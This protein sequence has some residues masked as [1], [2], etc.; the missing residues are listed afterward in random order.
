MDTSTQTERK[1][2]NP[3]PLGVWNVAGI[4]STAQSVL[5][6]LGVHSNY[7][8]DTIIGVERLVAKTKLSKRAVYKGLQELYGKG[9]ISRE[10]RPG[11]KWGRTSSRTRIWLTAEELTKAGA[12]DLSA[13]PA[14]TPEEIAVVA[15]KN[16]AVFRVRS[17]KNQKV[18]E[19]AGTNSGCTTCAMSSSQGAG[20]AHLMVQQVQSHG[21]PCAPE[22]SGF[23]LP[24]FNLQESLKPPVQKQP[25]GRSASTKEGKSKGN[26][27]PTVLS[28]GKQVKTAPCRPLA[29]RVN[30][31]TVVAMKP[32]V[33]A[34]FIAHRC[35]LNVI[36]ELETHATKMVTIFN[37]ETDGGCDNPITSYMTFAT[38]NPKWKALWYPGEQG[39]YEDFSE[40]AVRQRR[41]AHWEKTHRTEEQQDAIDAENWWMDLSLEQRGA[42]KSGLVRVVDEDG[43]KVDSAIE[44]WRR[45]RET[46]Q[47]AFARMWR[48]KRDKKQKELAAA[49]A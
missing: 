33:R 27:N 19:G 35:P 25:L 23:N 13:Y 42:F 20:G 9:R 41:D 2:Y 8:G 43:F 11:H 30:H 15:E 12:E 14:K 24:S 7:L 38:N 1:P 44:V 45:E 49:A 28:D 17:E 48:R 26:G 47:S 34:M 18:K 31:G 16:K 29:D 21:A 6:C 46:C 36:A 4:S 5:G 40:A 22:P 39:L 3:Y 37:D 10:D 32:E